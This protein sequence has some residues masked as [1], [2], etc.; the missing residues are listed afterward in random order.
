MLKV[1]LKPKTEALPGKCKSPWIR[2]SAETLRDCDENLS[3]MKTKR[4]KRFRM[5][6][7]ETGEFGNMKRMTVKLKQEKKM[8]PTLREIE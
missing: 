3:P 7:R 2:V 4:D 6:S 5:T 1:A 8:T